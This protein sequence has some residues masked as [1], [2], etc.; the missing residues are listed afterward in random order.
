[1]ETRIET[2]FSTAEKIRK[3]CDL[4]LSV[5]GEVEN[6]ISTSTEV[7]RSREKLS[8]V[9]LL[10][11]PLAMIMMLKKT[12]EFVGQVKQKI[13]GNNDKV[14]APVVEEKK[15]EKKEEKEENKA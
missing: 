9:A 12:C 7:W 1:M 3:A 2:F 11:R 8:K 4:T 10:R 13:N 14:Q 15:E 5:Q 6:L